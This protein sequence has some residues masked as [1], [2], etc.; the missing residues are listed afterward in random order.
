VKTSGSIAAK[1]QTILRISG[2]NFGNRVITG[3]ISCSLS[4]DSRKKERLSM[5]IVRSR[6]YLLI[7]YSIVLDVDSEFD[8]CCCSGK[9]LLGERIT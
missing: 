9:D 3:R 1:V 2:G 6:S 7:W 5:A 4:K 8:V